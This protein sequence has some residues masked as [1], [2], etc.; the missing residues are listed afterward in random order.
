M[1]DLVFLFLEREGDDLI[2]S[3]NHHEVLIPAERL[4][5]RRARWE[6]MVSLSHRE[7]GGPR[8]LK[9]Q[10]RRFVA[11][12][13]RSILHEW[14]FEHVIAPLVSFMPRHEFLLMF[15]GRSPHLPSLDVGRSLQEAWRRRLLGED[16]L[17]G[18]TVVPAQASAETWRLMDAI[19]ADTVPVVEAAQT[20][21]LVSPCSPRA[22]SVAEARVWRAARQA[23]V[24]LAPATCEALEGA[25]GA[26]ER[27]TLLLSGH[28]V[29]DGIQ[30][31]DGV[32]PLEKA[33]RVAGQAAHHSVLVAL[34][35][36]A[37]NEAL[38]AQFRAAGA[39]FVVEQDTLLTREAAL[40]ELVSLCAELAASPPRVLPQLQQR[41]WLREH[42]GSDGLR[43][44]R[45]A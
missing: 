45:T 7:S 18:A 25:L 39:V 29:G 9:Q 21:L 23:G 44:R 31:V 11:D 42:A 1:L 28:V 19:L 20:T 6:A 26:S 8:D 43:A 13:S 27:G 32:F 33:L 12:L 35:E 14:D 22:T 38:A 24:W 34:D 4:S 10:E 15:D 30:C 16:F 5:L 37:A 36:R 41:A 2:A 40:G 17:R 3:V